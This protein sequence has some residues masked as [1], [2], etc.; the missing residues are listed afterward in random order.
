MITKFS[1]EPDYT[2]IHS[3]W[4]KAWHLQIFLGHFNGWARLCQFTQF[5]SFD[6]SCA[7]SS[8]KRWQ[9]FMATHCVFFYS[10]TQKSIEIEI[11]H[12]V[13]FVF[14]L[15]GP[16]PH[17]ICCFQFPMPHI[18]TNFWYGISNVCV[19]VCAARFENCLWLTFC[20]IDFTFKSINMS[21]NAKCF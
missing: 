19:C 4:L 6:P 8:I 15:L 20:S 18:S 1:T 17:T 16:L 21:Q 12:S 5:S 3:Y 14:H 7:C 10:N 13:D 9:P 11:F 2:H